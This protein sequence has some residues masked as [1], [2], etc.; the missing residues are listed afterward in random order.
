[1]MTE[2]KSSLKD[3]VYQVLL[4]KILT[5]EL[6]PGTPLDEMKLCQMLKV[7]RTPIREALN[8]LERQNFVEMIP[9]KG[10]RVSILSLDSMINLFK[11]RRVVE[12]AL[13]RIACATI[14]NRSTELTEFKKRI[15]KSIEAGDRKNL[16]SIDYEFH[17]FL[18]EQSG[19]SHLM[20]LMNYITNHS[21]QIRS[22]KAETD[23]RILEAAREHIEIIDLLVAGELEKACS[24][25]QQHIQN[26]E[27][28]FVQNLLNN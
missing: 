25:M 2:S 3:Q 22:Q 5:N 27:V 10:A 9:K 16:N 4:R 19:N 6:Q 24:L 8:R 7:S 28:T 11:V 14:Q 20:F 23:A 21:W 17:A 15:L 18:Y 13:M 12:P 1:M 26:T